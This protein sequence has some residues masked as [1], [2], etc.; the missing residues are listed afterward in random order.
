MHAAIISLF[1]PQLPHLWVA[2]MSGEKKIGSKF[3]IN[4]VAQ[5]LEA[6]VFL[7]CGTADTVSLYKLHQK[8]LY[9]PKNL[10]TTL[11]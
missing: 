8:W 7:S 10:H 11:L 2:N 5:L 9:L 3:W 4:L 6:V 1:T